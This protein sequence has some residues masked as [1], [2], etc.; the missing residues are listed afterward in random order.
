MGNIGQ[1]CPAKGGARMATEPAY[2]SLTQV[3]HLLGVHYETAARWVRTGKLPGV[4]LS[5]R[6]VVVP[7]ENLDALL[8]G[9]RNLVEKG[10]S[11]PAGSAAPPGAERRPAA[12]SSFPPNK[13]PP[14]W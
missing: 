9:K 2:Y 6:K 11:L 4:K 1:R 12:A 13:A 5:R 7:K 14:R 10:D 3:A 8:A